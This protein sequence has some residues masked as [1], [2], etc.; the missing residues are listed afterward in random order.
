MLLLAFHTNS[1]WFYKCITNSITF[2]KAFSMEKRLKMYPT[3]AGFA[4]QY[5]QIKLVS[6]G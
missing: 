6:K 5:L 2:K 1:S 3:P 4:N